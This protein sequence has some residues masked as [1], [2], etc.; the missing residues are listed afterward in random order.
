MI[1]NSQSSF[2]L[3]DVCSESCMTAHG[4]SGA[5]DATHWRGLCQLIAPMSRI[6]Q[7]GCVFQVKKVQRQV[8]RR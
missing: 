7:A 2:M 8:T 4:R 6:D 5:Q 3:A 1:W